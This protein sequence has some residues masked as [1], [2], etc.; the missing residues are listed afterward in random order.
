VFRSL[1]KFQRV[2]PRRPSDKAVARIVK[3]RA[4]AFACAPRLWSC[5]GRRDGPADSRI[6]W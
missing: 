2:Q 6:R 4:E 1:G 5:G 3:R